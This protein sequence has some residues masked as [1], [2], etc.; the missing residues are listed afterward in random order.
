MDSNDDNVIRYLNGNKRPICIDT[1]VNFEG[2]VA[3]MCYHLRIDRSQSNVHVFIF[4]DASVVP[5]KIVD[6]DNL[7]YVMIIVRSLP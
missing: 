7:E 6:D 2:F 1:N 5:I 4:G 3:K